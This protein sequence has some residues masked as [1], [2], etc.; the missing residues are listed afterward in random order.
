[1]DMEI[2]KQIGDPSRTAL[3]IWDV[4]RMLV[5]GI[6]N[7][8]EFLRNTM[9]LVDQARKHRVPIFFT[10]ITPLP[11]RFE[12][13]V[14]R[15][16]AKQRMRKFQLTAEGLELA[17]EPGEGDIVIHKNT[18]SIF[19]GTNFEMMLRNA[20]IDTIVFTGIATEFG[21]E[22]SG[23]D[24]S[25]RGFYPLIAEDAVSSSDREAHERSLRN[26]Q[27][28]LFVFPSK[29]ICEMWNQRS[30]EIGGG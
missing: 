22:S 15:L 7:K 20:G 9:S 13:P 11:E 1:M 6:F 16:L 28:L 5:N 23:R 24:A 27:K 14:R 19:I 26:M 8:E 30:S 2:R 4:Q 25:N 29:E 21:I 10:K 3:I 12:S 17:I 18:A